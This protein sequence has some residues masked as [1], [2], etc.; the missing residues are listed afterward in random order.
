M[1]KYVWMPLSSPLQSWGGDA[2]NYSLRPTED[3]PTFSAV[4]GILCSCMGISFRNELDAVSDLR[5]N[6]K[7]DIYVRNKGSS[8]RDFQVSGGGIAKGC[9]DFY[10]RCV[11]NGS[12]KVYNKEYLQD[13]SFDVVLRID[14]EEL[15]DKI[16]CALKK[17]MWEPFLGRRANHL[18]EF[19]FGGIYDS[20]KAIKESWEKKDR[21]HSVCFIHTESGVPIKDFPL[22]RGDNYNGYRYSQEFFLKDREYE[23]L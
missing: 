16:V 18:S 14:D 21:M 10:K 19:P 9:S 23:C 8:L 6:I 13:A 15:A 7:I 11:P 20:K 12:N 2:I 1:T 3:I 22:C 5:D 17:P 4:L